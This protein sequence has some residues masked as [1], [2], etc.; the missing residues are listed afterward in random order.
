MIRWI[1]SKWNAFKDIFVSAFRNITVHNFRESIYSMGFVFGTCVGLLNMSVMALS[2]G[3]QTW[4]P[5]VAVWLSYV[6]AC[7][8]TPCAL[9]G[10]TFLILHWFY[11]KKL[12]DTVSW[13]TVNKVT[14]VSHFLTRTTLWSTIFYVIF[15]VFW[16]SAPFHGYIFIA[17]FLP[18]LVAVKSL[19]LD[20]F[21]IPL[22]IIMPT[23]IWLNL[24][25]I[26]F[27]WHMRHE[28]LERIINRED[29]ST[30]S[31]GDWANDDEI[32]DHKL[33][34]MGL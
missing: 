5:M 13:W 1:K 26:K 19:I 33:A 7:I 20:M 28:E 10:L 12:D 2:F 23:A 6:G 3:L 16:A 31:M 29:R 11:L 21:W 34:R 32:L 14:N 17:S 4:L 15:L 8:L 30:G 22:C 9:I 27:K 25:F 18:N 24:F